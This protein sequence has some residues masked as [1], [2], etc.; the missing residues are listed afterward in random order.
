[1]DLRSESVT[2][3]NTLKQKMKLAVLLTV[4]LGSVSVY[5]A[6]QKG[7]DKKTPPKVVVP[8]RNDRDKPK[9]PS[10]NRNDNR[11]RRPNG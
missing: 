6:A 2:M 1:M 10:D 5:V 7:D 11:D 4:L 3:G 8:P 9:P